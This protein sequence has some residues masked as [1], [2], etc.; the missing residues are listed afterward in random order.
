MENNVNEGR[1]PFLLLQKIWRIM[2]ITTLFIVLGIVN[3]MATEAYSQK[4]RV[5][6]NLSDAPLEVVLDEIEKQSEF[7]FLFDQNLI[8]IDRKVHVN[9]KNQK[10]GKILDKLF[11]NTDITYRVFDRQIV[12]TKSDV[13]GTIANGKDGLLLYDSNP[14]AEERA[15]RATSNVLS[16]ERVISGQLKDATDGSPLIGA[17]VIEKGTNNGT[18]TDVEGK[19]RLIVS[20]KATTLVFSYI[21]Y[22]TQEISIGNQSVIDVAL[23]PDLKQLE[24]IVVV[25]YGSVKKSDLTGSVASVSSE[26]LT[27][28]PAID[29]AQALQGRAAGVTVTSTNG[30]PGAP[31]RIQIRGNTSINASSAPLIVVD[32][33]VGGVMPPPEDIKSMEILKDASATAIY[34]SRGAN[35]VIMITTN[36]GRKGK[37]QINFSSSWTS[38]TPTNRLELLNG[39]QYAEYVNEVSPGFYP[40]PA[41][42]GQGTD[43]QD[44]IYRTGGIQ[45]YQLSV[46][47]GSDNVNYYVSGVLFDQ[48]GVV[49]DSQFKRYSLTSNVNI[50]ASEVFSFGANL[51]TRR[52]VQY[53][54]RSQEGGNASQTGVISGAYKFAPTLG[55]RDDE[56]NFTVADRGFPIDNPFALATELENETF[57]DVFQ[58]NLYA[59]INLFEGLKFRTTMGANINSR[60]SGQYY[61]R[62]LERGNAVD[63]EATLGFA[64]STNFITENY[65]TYNKTIANVHDI[66][67]M[68]G[69]SY[70]S[71]RRES[72]NTITSGFISDSF[73][74]WN[75]G[76]G[77]NEPY[78]SSATVFSEISS[79]YGRLNY[80]FNNKY[81][82][83]F[84]ARYDGSSNFAANN[85]WAFFPSAAFAW[86][87]SE[88]SFLSSSSLVDVLKLRLSYG[89]TGNQSI[90]PFQS[91]ASFTTVLTTVQG[92][93]APALRPGS[94]GN[95]DLTWET[96]TQTDIGID[97]AIWQSR[98][99]FTADY[100]DMKTTD[101]LFAMPLPLYSGFASQL[102]NI[103]TVQNKGVEFTVSGEIL[104][105]ELKWTTNANISFNRNKI[106]E[107][108]ENDTE[109]NDI[110][111]GSAP[112]PGGGNV[113]LL[114]E[115]QP[116]GLFWGY[117][118]LGVLQNGDTQLVNGEGVGGESFMD[119]DAN[120]TLTAEDRTIIGD[121]NPDFT[122]GWNNT[123]S[124]KGF[125]LNVF[126]QGSQGGDLFNFTLMELG[127]LEGDINTTVDALNRWTPQNTNTDVPMANPSRQF[128]ASD[129]W[130][131]DGSYIR[132][133]NI[134][135]GYNFPAS[136]LSKINM[137]SARVYVSGQNLFTITG[138]RGLDPEVAYRSSSSTLGLDYGS[139]PQ[140]RSYTVGLNIGF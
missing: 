17:N 88:E 96:T 107:L 77:V 111:Y 133:K 49:K 30:E 11:K 100:Y 10:I 101:L 136:L 66:S 122:W 108:P 90:R 124:Y 114:R 31:F 57:L 50:K 118:Y 14:G 63:G 5:T 80:S 74:W 105:G 7:Y 24:E 33:F 87:I 61:P 37:P 22:E 106:L 78:L 29:A 110:L 94:P 128:V 117:R 16:A 103:G 35:G 132:V 52:S 119:L 3:V 99:A 39:T 121:P 13:E 6:L 8:D 44:E 71:D 21:G 73:S 115:G 43:W 129:R 92:G 42:F 28:Y 48:K 83:T 1:V 53:G 62:T 51:F 47:G 102:A 60:R 70:Q 123:F 38:Q 41:S 137:R 138:Y 125:E 9:V 85:K 12:L 86:N 36:S 64:K 130:V 89:Q 112:L 97:L 127:R 109:G 27:A 75:I 69:Y 56:G 140:V 126:I 58:S 4:A 79:F 54:T 91:L 65:L 98:L 40:D 82:L 46:G 131:E 45:N 84:N 72:L 113:L 104:T 59:E 139:Y 135:L 134:S 19:Y 120:D 20:E 116:V 76:A 34:G 18:V 67:I 93:E 55:I 32:G 81:L 2:K 95:P 23:L 25:G 15:T 68:G 26:D